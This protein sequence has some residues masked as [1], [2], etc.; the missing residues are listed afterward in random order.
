VE[1][2][3]GEEKVEVIAIIR[4]EKRSQEMKKRK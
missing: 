2:K 1:K 4:R 3:N